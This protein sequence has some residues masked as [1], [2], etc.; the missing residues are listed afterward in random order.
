MKKE[1]ITTFFFFLDKINTPLV[2]KNL[3]YIIEFYIYYVVT[4]GLILL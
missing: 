2:F 4:T 3:I 1:G